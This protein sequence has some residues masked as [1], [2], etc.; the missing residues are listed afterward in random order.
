MKRGFDLRWIC[1]QQ[2]KASS[3][4]RSLNAGPPLNTAK[5]LLSA[6]EKDKGLKSAL[7]H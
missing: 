1:A 5:V 2:I 7:L 3:L 6:S 4:V